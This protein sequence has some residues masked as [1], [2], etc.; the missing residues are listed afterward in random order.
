MDPLLAT[1]GRTLILCL[2]LHGI[3]WASGFYRKIE[4]T[5]NPIRVK[6]V[7]IIFGLYYLVQ[8]IMM[9]VIISIFFIEKRAEGYQLVMSLQERGWY[10]FAAMAVIFLVVLPYSLTRGKKVRKYLWQGTLKNFLLGCITWLLVLPLAML[11]TQTIRA[12]YIEVLQLPPYD[13]EQN[14]VR[15]LMETMEYPALFYSMTFAVMFLVPIAEEILFRGFL[16]PVFNHIFP[17]GASIAITSLIFAF[18]HYT[19]DQGVGNIELLFNLFML[20]CFLGY[21]FE[22]EKSLWAPIGLHIT[23]NSLSVIFLILDFY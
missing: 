15:T 11:I 3:A 18:M 16:Q 7:F 14:A 21:L 10:V 4:K 12:V 13:L 5:D 20:S 22:R 19:Y 1:I 23:F 6:Q 17:V 8:L 9:P 2:L